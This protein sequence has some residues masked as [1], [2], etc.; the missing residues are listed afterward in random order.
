MINA[1]VFCRSLGVAPSLQNVQR[2][3]WVYRSHPIEQI[4][5]WMEKT[6]IENNGIKNL[7]IACHG[8]HAYVNGSEDLVGGFGIL[9]GTGLHEGNVHLMKKLQRKVSNIYLYSCGAAAEPSKL[10]QIKGELQCINPNYIKNNRRMCSKMSDYTE[11]NVYA[12]DTFQEYH[13]LRKFI[14]W[15]TFDLGTWEGKV[16]KFVPGKPPI[17]VTGRMHTFGNETGDE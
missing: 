9:L 13:K 11:A 12:S 7:L 2:F 4:L 15:E 8:G 17:D 5:N 14:F 1:L 10:D 16:E 6:A 3:H